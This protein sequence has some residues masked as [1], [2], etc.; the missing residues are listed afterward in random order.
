MVK[1]SSSNLADRQPSVSLAQLP[2]DLSPWG[3]F[4]HADTIVKAVMIGLAF[5]SLVTWTI[6]IA[7]SIELS[8]ALRK[9]KSQ[10][11]Q[12][13]DARSLAEAQ[14]AL[15]RKSGVLSAFIVI[16][17]SVMILRKRK[18]DLPRSFRTPLVPLVPL[19]GIG[20]SIW[21]LSELPA[22]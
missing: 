1:G 2:Q 20:F 4:L 9:L 17:T 11:D 21:L 18:P 22:T 15:G 7:K 5:A 19:I 14:M 12:V 16:C 13:D 3:M 6:F 10:L 8:L